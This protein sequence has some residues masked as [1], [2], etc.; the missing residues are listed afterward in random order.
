VALLHESKI[1]RYDPRHP[2]NG[3]SHYPGPMLDFYFTG[4]RI[5]SLKYRKNSGMTAASYAHATKLSQI[6]LFKNPN[7]ALR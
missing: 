4:S 3:V 5:F 2:G 1:K 6:F 7:A